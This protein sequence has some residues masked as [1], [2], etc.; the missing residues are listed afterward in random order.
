MIPQP[1]PGQGPIDPQ[2]AFPNP[3][4]MGSPQGTVPSQGTA[5]AAPVPPV[6]HQQQSAKP[7]A[8]LSGYAPPPGVGG[9]VNP[10][11]GA[12]MQMQMPQMMPPSP[13]MVPPG[14]MPMPFPYPPPPRRG[15]M[16]RAIF[17]ALL[18]MLLLGSVL[19]NLVLVAGSLGGGSAG[20]QQQTL[21]GGGGTD[22]VAIVPIRGIIDTGASMQFDRFMDM[23]Q[24]DKAVKAVVIEID[25]PG[26]TVT[27]SDEIYN[28]IK[29]FKS[30]KS[31]PIVVSM[32]SLATSGGYYAACGADY[33]FA[34]PTT[35][36]GNIGVL[37][38]RYNFS[39]LMEKYGVE[40]T[41][42]VSSGARFKNAGSSF[43][44]E[45]PEEKQ[46]MQ[47]LADSAFTQFK[48][49]V[50][51]GRNSRLKAN[52]EDVANGKVYTANNALNMGLID[53]VGYLED[54]HTYAASAAGLSSPTV[55]RYHDPPSLL[56]ILMASSN[57]GGATAR[58]EGVSVTVDQ[59]L[60]QDL[61]TPRPLY[62]W[63]GQ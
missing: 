26:G 54:A 23:A 56:Q 61:T 58:G 36:T 28:R 51:A 21:Q 46:Y 45:S 22:K 55:I 29:A 9:Q 42:I 53:Q 57:V 27:A 63:R 15:G 8:G 52:M 2:G 41:T 4:G 31:V 39:K 49:V 20:I 35:F 62:L 18:L 43:R 48:N 6:G 19:L 50:T 5:P 7:Q 24:A 25:S 13:G 3:Q 37:M 30:K 11:M 16:G 47:E 17:V 32:G 59:K 12:P 1:P 38:P 14:M 44:P 40:E 60:L 10:Y 33:V 34:Q